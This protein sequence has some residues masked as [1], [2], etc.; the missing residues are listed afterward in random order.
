MNQVPQLLIERLALGELSDEEARQVRARLEAAGELHRLAEIAS[1]NG[2]ILK[3]LPP[4]QVAREVR[5]RLAED[6]WRRRRRRAV[7]VPILVA[8]AAVF[9]F[10]GEPEQVLGDY[11]EEGVRLKGLEPSLRVYRNATPDP[12]ELG[13]GSHAAAGDVLQ[14]GYIAAGETYG[15]IVSQDG[16]GVL[17]EHFRGDLE[18]GGEI[19]LDHAYELD[20]APSHETFYF[21]SSRRAISQEETE[22]VIGLGSADAQ[23][24]V[25]VY[26]LRLEKEESP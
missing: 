15:V 6:A 5:A 13:N 26:V 16:R 11:P 9:A 21:L 22:R 4:E 25:S 18:P 7:L 24:D 3:T 14:L 20:D 8:A 12:L 19:R 23:Q 1:S 10:Q 17:T 2:E